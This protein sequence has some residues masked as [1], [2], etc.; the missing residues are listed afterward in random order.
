MTETMRPHP[1]P[2]HLRAVADAIE[3]AWEVATAAA[4]PRT[5][6]EE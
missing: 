4:V 6:I 1:H 3:D 2:G 5:V